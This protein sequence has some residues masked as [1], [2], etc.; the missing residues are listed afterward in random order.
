MADLAQ[1]EPSICCFID[2]G[3]RPSLQAW[4]HALGPATPS[5]SGTAAPKPAGLQDASAASFSRALH[6]SLAAYL[7]T[8]LPERMF[9][10]SFAM[11]YL[12]IYSKAA[13]L[14]AART[15]YCIV[16]PPQSCQIQICARNSWCYRP[17]TEV[18]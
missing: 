18:T 1:P 5:T 12:G 10:N 3:D 8:S 14:S 4:S 7:L 2:L 11:S 6:A 15:P 13:D 16:H 17:S 9:A